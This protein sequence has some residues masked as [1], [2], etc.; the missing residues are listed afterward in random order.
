MGQVF[1]RN[2]KHKYPIAVG[3]D[4]PYVFDRDSKRYLDACGEAAVSCLGHSDREVISAIKTQLD[5]LPFARTRTRGATPGV[6][7]RNRF[8][9]RDCGRRDAGLEARL[10]ARFGQHPNVGEIRGGGRFWALELVEYGHRSGRSMRSAGIS[11]TLKLQALENGLLCYPMAGTLDGAS[12]DHIVL[13]PPSII[14]EAQTGRDR[15][16]TRALDR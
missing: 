14:N 10:R 8:Y 2:P 12:G 7:Q 11:T 4:G 1:H 16:Q 13:A 5:Q 3:G 6:R 9:R 15:R